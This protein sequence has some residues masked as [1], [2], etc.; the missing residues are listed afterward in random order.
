VLK[1]AVASRRKIKGLNA[2]KN[3]HQ[4]KFTKIK[5]EARADGFVG[6]GR[7]SKKKKR[8]WGEQCK[9][10]NRE[11]LPSGILENRGGEKN[12]QAG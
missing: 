8:E 5:T 2:Q 4:K 6:W 7:E 1:P 11:T 9:T 10:S 12:C 3:L